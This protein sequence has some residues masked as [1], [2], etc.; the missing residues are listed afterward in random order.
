[1]LRFVSAGESHGQALIAW[2]SGLPAGVPVDLEFIQRELHRRQLGYGRGGRQRIEKDQPDIVAGVRHG[3]TIGAPIAVRIENRDW[4][5]WEKALPVEDTE[6][7]DDAQRPLTAPRPGHADLA[8][9]LKFNFH[10]ARYVLE[11]ASARETASRVAAGAFAKMLLRE[12]GAAVLSH[13]IA[14]G[15]ARL[16]REA[17]WEEIEEV[18]EDLESPLRCVDATTEAKMK[19]EVDHALRAGDS[20]GG[21]FEVVA[22]GI[23][24]G[25]GNHAQ[26]DEKLDAR[27]ARAVMSIQ[28]VKAVEL[29][30]GI[31]NASSYG[32][33][34]QDEI[35][36][37]A[38]RKRFA[39]SSN[40]AGGL[41]GGI[42]NGQDIVVRGYL[43]PI[44]TLRR[45]LLTAD[46]KTKEAVKAAYERSDVCV[47]P[48]AGV[49]GEAMVALELAGAFLEKFGGD[50]LG[51]TRRNFDG[52]QKQLDE[53]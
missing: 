3:K 26:W 47:V 34:V 42:A 43:K 28:A 21:V 14:V 23:W 5:N 38:A 32:S 13:T 39:R 1:M 24:P 7:A 16:E 19:A 50:S 15:H 45:P 2:V 52:Y 41:E 25:L 10:D 53:F 51:E 6:G 27:L 31:A 29:G 8:G 17:R 44:S 18:C 37:D 9:A 35:R 4:A 33:E 49:A 20:V 48:A 30:S 11:R 46:L 22:H 36:Y 12:F 40:R